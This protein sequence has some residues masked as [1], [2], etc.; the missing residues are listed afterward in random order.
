MV[1]QHRAHTKSFGQN[2]INTAKHENQMLKSLSADMNTNS[3][4]HVAK[5]K[6]NHTPS[7]NFTRVQFLNTEERGG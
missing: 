1:Q 2:C 3:P 6:T 5:N 7:S 4:P